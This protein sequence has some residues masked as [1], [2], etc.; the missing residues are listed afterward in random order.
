MIGNGGN[1]LHVY[2]RPINPVPAFGTAHLF[3]THVS[4]LLIVKGHL[5]GT[6]HTRIDQSIEPTSG[7]FDADVLNADREVGFE[8]RLHVPLVWDEFG[9]ADVLVS[10]GYLES[11]RKI[12][13]ERKKRLEDSGVDALE[14]DLRYSHMQRRSGRSTT[15]WQ[16][17]LTHFEATTIEP[18]INALS[19][20]GL[21]VLVN[22]SR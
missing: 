10:E 17:H 15:F 13:Q 6:V 8:S 1:L 7:L 2:F 5:D 9:L 21:D 18:E 22:H 19:A 14:D 4:S 12:V 20:L 3:P 16:T 11:R